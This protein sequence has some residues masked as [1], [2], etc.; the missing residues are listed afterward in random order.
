METIFSVLF[1]ILF[2][3]ARAISLRYEIAV[4]IK[5]FVQPQR[6]RYNDQYHSGYNKNESLKYRCFEP[7]YIWPISPDYSFIRYSI[8]D[9]IS[10]SKI[11]GDGGS[12]F[13]FEQRHIEEFD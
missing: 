8:I 5:I 3:L 13:K 10:A 6:V 12:G 11:S 9:A 7:V 1:F 2:F 4:M